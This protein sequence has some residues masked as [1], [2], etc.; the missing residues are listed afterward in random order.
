MRVGEYKTS[1]KESNRFIS[2]HIYQVGG[3]LEVAE[4]PSRVFLQSKE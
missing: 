1:S 3:V 2:Q 4:V